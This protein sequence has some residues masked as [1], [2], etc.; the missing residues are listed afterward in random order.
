MK[1]F[2]HI[3]DRVLYLLLFVVLAVMATIV[4]ANVFGRFVLHKSISW[5]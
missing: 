4:A 3:L 5:G 2:F 1:S